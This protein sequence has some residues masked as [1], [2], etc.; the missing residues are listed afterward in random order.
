MIGSRGDQFWFGSV[1]AKKSNQTEIKKK[2]PKP[3]GLPVQTDRF[4][5]FFGQKTVQTGFARFS[6]LA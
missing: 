2:K 6:S 4:G 3:V 5:S 1:L